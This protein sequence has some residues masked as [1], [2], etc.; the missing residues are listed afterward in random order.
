MSRAHPPTHHRAPAS[1]APSRRGA[2]VKNSYHHYVGRHCG[3]TEEGAPLSTPTNPD[4]LTRD[5]CSGFRDITYSECQAKCDANEVPP[6]CAAPTS[7]CTAGTFFFESAQPRT[8][9]RALTLTLYP[10]P[11][12]NPNP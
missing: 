8:R 7:T 1:A 11:D 3:E 4:A 2:C 9:A 12:P 10:N 6:G 5:E